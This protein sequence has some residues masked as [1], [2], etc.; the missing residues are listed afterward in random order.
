MLTVSEWTRISPASTAAV[1][2]LRFNSAAA[3]STSTVTVLIPSATSWPI[4]EPSC[5]A[6]AM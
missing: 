2:G 3:P 5:S 6:S 4:S 1:I